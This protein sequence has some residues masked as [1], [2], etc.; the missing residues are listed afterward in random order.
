M[1][2]QQIDAAAAQVRQALDA[3]M[4]SADFEARADAAC[5]AIQAGGLRTNEELAEALGLPERFLAVA[6]QKQKS[7]FFAERGGLQ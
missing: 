1:T 3:Y 7:K 4:A 5:A 6:L 2:E